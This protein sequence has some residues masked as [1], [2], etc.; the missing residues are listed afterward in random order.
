MLREP[1]VGYVE[2]MT[3]IDRFHRVRDTSTGVGCRRSR[4]QPTLPV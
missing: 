2:T 3:V 4:R 1:Q